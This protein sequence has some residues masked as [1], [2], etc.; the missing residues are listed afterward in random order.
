MA[1]RALQITSKISLTLYL[2]KIVP[3]IFK[4]QETN[5]NYTKNQTTRF[6]GMILYSRLSWEQHIV[7]IR[8][9]SK[10]A[11]YTIKAISGEHSLIFIEKTARHNTQQKTHSF[12][13]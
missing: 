7:R 13:L 8:A 9:K 11:L 5:R 10:D 6:L 12:L 4:T 2:S 1:T 3:M